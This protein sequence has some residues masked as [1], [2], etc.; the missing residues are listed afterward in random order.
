MTQHNIISFWRDIEI[1][2]LPDMDYRYPKY[3]NGKIL[4]W[5]KELNSTTKNKVSS[6]TIY[7]G[8]F[9]KSEIISQIEKFSHK[10]IIDNS[11][12]KEPVLGFTCLAEIVLDENGCLIQNGYLHASYLYGLNCLVEKKPVSDVVQRLNNVIEEFQLRNPIKSPNLN[13]INV[14]NSN[15]LNWEILN[16]EIIYLK[17][18][19]NGWLTKEISVYIVENET[20]KEIS[21]L[22][23]FYLEELNQIYK[24]PDSFGKSLNEYLSIDINE[25]KRIDVIED[26]EQLL[27]T[28]DPIN[29]PTGRWPSNIKYG[30]YTAQLGAV[31]TA[32]YE[33]KTVGGIRGINGPPGT[34][35]TTLLKDI[36]ADIVV[37]RAKR[38]LDNNNLFLKYEKIENET[39][40]SY[41]FYNVNTTVFSDCGIVVS[42]NN[43]TAVENITKELPSCK[44]L[45]PE[46]IKKGYFSESSQRLVDEPSWGV[47]SAALGNKSNINNFIKNFWENGKSA[48]EIGFNKLIWSIYDNKNNDKTDEMRRKFD[49]AKSNLSNLLNKWEAFQNEASYF[50]QLLPTHISNLK[51]LKVI[52][53]E[54]DNLNEQL[55]IELKFSNEYNDKLLSIN[56]E[57]NQ[58][59]K[60]ITLQNSQKPTLFFIHKLFNT[61]MYKKWN[62]SIINYLDDLQKISVEHSNIKEKYNDCKQ[63]IKSLSDQIKLKQINLTKAKKEINDYAEVREELVVKYQ[64]DKSNLVDENFLN[65][66]F[67]KTHLSNPYSSEQLNLLRSEIFIT[68][69]EVH[70][71]AILSHP[72]QFRNNLELFFNV[73]NGSK[74]VNKEIELQLWDTFF[75]CIPVVSTTLASVGKLFGSFGKEKIGWLLLDEAGQATPQSAIGIIWR[76]K[77]C[78]IV[79]DPLQIEPV[80]TAPKNLVKSLRLQNK[81]QDNTW[82]PLVSSVQKLADRISTKGTYMLQANSEEKI[83]TGFPLRTHRRCNNPMFEIANEIAYLNQ[84]VKAEEDDKTKENDPIR[85]VWYDV[86]GKEI[87]NKQ[88]VID[89]LN[90]LSEK[91]NDL[92]RNNYNGQ[93]F[94]ITPFNSI[95]F[96][97]RKLFKSDNMIS[98]GT[99]HKFQGKEADIV[100]VILGTDPESQGSRKWASQAPNMLNVALTRA[101]KRCYVIGSKKLW[102]ELEY[103]NVMAKKLV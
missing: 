50:H 98:C 49:E 40:N 44:N 91:V 38:I 75:F 42:S 2:N 69:L 31:C 65:L 97:C 64:I 39:G 33:L 13:E 18:I 48:N 73:I 74:K 67:D 27:S 6:Y 81:L 99:I 61:L 60:S 88:V 11:D 102:S 80:V 62:Q 79:G 82:S 55:N 1:F 19:T 34:G 72:K 58:L 101:K 95:A 21:F 45:V 92:R 51:L 100:F 4:P 32:L 94:I 15:S 71:Y 14:Q 43:N 47:L 7:F 68:S 70:K 90:L 24:S 83:W 30:L 37:N 3:E 63:L 22:N 85:S 53:L 93:I 28:L 87:I 66:P 84:M 57:I 56:Q 54:I 52:T 96:E 86:E 25:T 29:I 17:N 41:H 78:I 8:C 10:E 16:T 9:S 26:K 89:E 35:K 76:S 5:Q 23:S 46:L 36:I 20:P 103:F 77:R 59:Q 12:W